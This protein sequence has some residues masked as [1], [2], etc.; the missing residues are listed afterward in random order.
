[1]VHPNLSWTKLALIL[2]FLQF[3]KVSFSQY[4]TAD[5]RFS[6]VE[7]FNIDQ[8]VTDYDLVYGNAVNW[9]GYS[10][11]LKI[12]IIYPDTLVDSMPLR[13]F[14]LL[15]HGGGFQNGN[16][17]SLRSDC[18]EFAKRGYVAATLGYRLGHNPANPVEQILAAY[19]AQQDANASLRF[20]IEN[21]E[22]YK[23]DTSWIF[24]GGGSAG[25][26]TALT[27]NYAS[28]EEWDVFVPGIEFLLGDL[29]TSGNTLPHT[30]SL[31]GILNNWGA[32][33]GQAIDSDE[34]VPMISFHG[35]LDQV[36][37]IDSTDNGLYG[38]RPIHYLLEDNG[39]CSDLSVKTDGYHGI[40][41]GQAGNIFR[42]NKASCFFKS[43]FCEDCATVYTTDSIPA[44]C[45]DTYSQIIIPLEMGWNGIST[46]LETGNND[47]ASMVEPL[48][49]DFICLQN[50][51]GMFYPS[52]NIS[53]IEDWQP[54]SGYLIKVSNDTELIMVGFSPEST[55]L[56]IGAGWSLMPVLSSQEVNITELIGNRI[57]AVEV[58]KNAAGI[59]VYWPEKN[60]LQ[61][62]KLLPGNSYFIKTTDTI[63]ISF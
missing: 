22:T 43:I 2:I 49:D 48:G 6:D 50:M 34:M 5:N 29:K 4:C 19:R 3:S 57:D 17:N 30:F 56:Q 45:S 35:E 10:Q 58:I 46:Y 18:R 9:Q 60:V 37:P 24:I 44:N 33:F 59:D 32:T 26:V 54:E 14:I 39:I 27:T 62:T 40:Y 31:K 21:A 55:T 28:Q 13:P 15:I 61:L 7:Y 16:K 11:D 42:T 36:V 52:G 63:S 23:I 47:I 53:T 25:A 8:I 51:E 38:S 41:G 12:D 1:M 20:I